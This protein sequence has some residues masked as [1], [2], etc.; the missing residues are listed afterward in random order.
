MPATKARFF[1]VTVRDG[2]GQSNRI[3]PAFSKEDLLSNLD[4]PSNE[5]LLGIEHLKHH[6]VKATPN[7]DED[8]VEFV[9][10]VRGVEVRVNPSDQGYGYLRQ[11]FP[12]QVKNVEDYIDHK[13][14]DPA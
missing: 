12:K 11:Q 8:A 2:H 10:K 9:A 4:I 14:S 3:V 7:E 13:Y 6:V 5:K 1:E